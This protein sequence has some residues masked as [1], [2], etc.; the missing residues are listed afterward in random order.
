MGAFEHGIVTETDVERFDPQLRREFELLGD[1]GIGDSDICSAVVCKRAVGMVSR[2]GCPMRL[3][4][5]RTSR[6]RDPSIWSRLTELTS[7]ELD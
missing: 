6:I 4:N 2:D 3:C 5:Q 1:G 7:M